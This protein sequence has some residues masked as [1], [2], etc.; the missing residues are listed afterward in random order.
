M[1][2]L[3]IRSSAV[4]VL[5][6]FASVTQAKAQGVSAYFGVGSATDGAATSAGCPSKTVFDEITTQCESAPTI[7]GAFGLIGADFLIL[8]H[9]GVNAEYSFRFAQANYLPGAGLNARPSFYDFNAV[10][11]PTTGERRIVPV[12]EG[13]IGGSR[14]SLYF[15]QASCVTQ[16]C[17]NSSQVV[18]TS[19]HFQL[20]GAVGVKLYVKSDIFIKPQFDLHWVHNLDQ[21]YGSD[22]VPQYTIAVGYTFGR[23]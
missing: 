14:L 18:A 17:Q 8:P 20:H 12:V 11:Q 16:V 13:G 19:N 10:Y 2:K 7:G 23:H 1:L 5:L 15:N 3:T 22:F 21:Q 9:L 6:L 4:F